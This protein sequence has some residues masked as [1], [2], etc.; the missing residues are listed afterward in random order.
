MQWH[1]LI[2]HRGPYDSCCGVQ[3][4]LTALLGQV[5]A[6]LSKV[7][8]SELHLLNLLTDDRTRIKIYA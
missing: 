2:R 5:Y 7:R 1:S 3:L 4:V 6:N 8:I